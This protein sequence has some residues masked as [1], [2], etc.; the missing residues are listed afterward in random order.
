[1]QRTLKSDL[2]V[3][4]PVLKVKT[5]EYSAQYHYLFTG[6]QYVQSETATKHELD[7]ITVSLALP[8]SPTQVS[9]QEKGKY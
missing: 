6:L 8:A 1:M 4:D 2:C 3:Q 9:L 7:C 5:V